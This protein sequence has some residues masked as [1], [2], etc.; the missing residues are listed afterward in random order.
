MAIPGWWA[1]V[2]VSDDEIP[3]VWT[4]WEPPGVGKELVGDLP[5]GMVVQHM[6]PRGV[7][8]SKAVQ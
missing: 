6:K 3:K 7:K 2:H 5:T 4:I 8:R 1:L